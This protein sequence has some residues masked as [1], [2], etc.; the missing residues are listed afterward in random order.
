MKE[1]KNEPGYTGEDS[2]YPQQLTLP[3]GDTI[4]VPGLTKL[5]LISAMCLQGIMS[6]PVLVGSW[7]VEHS[8]KMAIEN[9]RELLS[10][11]EAEND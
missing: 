11:L 9:A 6:N 4:I 10:Q 7:T 5:E 1:N 2:A 3:D 8:A